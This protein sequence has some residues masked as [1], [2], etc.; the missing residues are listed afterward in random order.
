[1]PERNHRIIHPITTHIFVFVSLRNTLELSIISTVDLG[2]KLDVLHTQFSM[3]QVFGA[4]LESV[5]RFARKTFYIGSIRPKLILAC[6]EV[7]R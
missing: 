6:K 1:M 5:W 7:L 2:G 4:C 3:F